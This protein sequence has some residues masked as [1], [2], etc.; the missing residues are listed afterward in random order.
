M[1]SSITN[2]IQQQE[3]I[4][5]NFFTQNTK[6][7]T[8]C[9]VILS[10]ICAYFYFSSKSTN[11]NM[12]PKVENIEPKVENMEPKVPVEI[13]PS[14]ENM[15]TSGKVLNYFGGKGCPHSNMNSMMYQ[16]VFNKLKNKYSDVNINLLWSDEKQDLFKEKNIQFVPTLLTNTDNKIN[17]KLNDIN[18][19]NYNDQEL[20]NLFLENVY[21]QL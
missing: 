17:T 20:E 16:M 3:T 7:I 4:I 1:D 13:P 8:I 21:K 10:I 19:D 14:T 18:T 12:E 11:E 6:I 5:Q 9:I 15:V 2:Q